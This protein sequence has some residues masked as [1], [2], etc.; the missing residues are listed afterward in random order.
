M[1]KILAV[2][3][4]TILYVLPLSVLAQKRAAAQTKVGKYEANVIYDAVNEFK[5]TNFEGSN[6][7]SYD[8][9]YT[10]K[11]HVQFQS[12]E[13]VGKVIRHDGTT[14]IVEPSEPQATGKFSYTHSGEEHH[15][16]NDGFDLHYDSKEDASYSGVLSK[17]GAIG[18]EFPDTGD[19][20]LNAQASAGG[21]GSGSFKRTI[22]REEYVQVPGTSVS[23]SRKQ[24]AKPEIDTECQDGTNTGPLVMSGN[25]DS[26]K[27]SESACAVDFPITSGAFN[28]FTKAMTMEEMQQDEGTWAGAKSTGSF[29]SGKYELTLAVTLKPKTWNTEIQNGINT[30]SETLSFAVTLTLGSA[31]AEIISPANTTDS[32]LLAEVLM[33]EDRLRF[34]LLKSADENSGSN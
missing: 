17:A 7:K 26:T 22:N 34:S 19:Q 33:S 10:T 21:I 24:Y 12:S 13:G 6:Y 15:V 4:I 8:A 27:P 16:S 14:S 32:N 5:Q 28:V 25:L 30:Y 18:A 29:A 2:F 23:Q 31:T 20:M 9:N 11:L 1:K 3:V